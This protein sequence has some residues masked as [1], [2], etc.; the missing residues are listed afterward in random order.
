MGIRE[1]ASTQA[2]LRGR[3]QLCPERGKEG[4]WTRNPRAPD[5]RRGG[6]MGGQS[7]GWRGRGIRAALCPQGSLALQEHPQTKK[8]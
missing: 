3:K 2:Q 4:G 7:W 5:P 6:R 1:V 8:P